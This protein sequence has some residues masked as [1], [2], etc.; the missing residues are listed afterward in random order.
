MKHKF[1]PQSIKH[2]PSE[3]ELLLEIKREYNI[4]KQEE[5]LGKEY[6]SVKPQ[7][8]SEVLQRLLK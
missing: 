5:E 1:L 6:I 2:L 3:E 7:I 4:L 8:L